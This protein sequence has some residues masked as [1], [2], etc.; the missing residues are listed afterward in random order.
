MQV[1]P[2][3]DLEAAPSWRC[4]NR[5]SSKTGGCADS[6]DGFEKITSL[7]QKRLREPN[8]DQQQA[9]DSPYRRPQ[10]SE[11]WKDAHGDP[12]IERND[13]ALL[14]GCHPRRQTLC[15]DRGPG[16]HLLRTDQDRTVSE[17]C[18]ASTGLI[19]RRFPPLRTGLLRTSRWLA[20]PFFK[21]TG[22]SPGLKV[23]PR[24]MHSSLNWL[25]LLFS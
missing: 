15:P 21:N 22:R 23:P 14:L 17:P 19:R 24:A 2:V 7:H 11:D 9:R 3:S 4:G 18:I 13:T 6:S 12:A 20:V 1:E 25:Y 8:A 5:G 10:Q 16:R